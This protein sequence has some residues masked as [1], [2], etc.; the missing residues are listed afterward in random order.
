MDAV[1]GTIYWN[2][3]DYFFTLRAKLSD[4]LIALL[5]KIM[6]DLFMFSHVK[7]QLNT[8]YQSEVNKIHFE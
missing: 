5:A 1:S 8:L 7:H 2:P 4:Q 6:D 3:V